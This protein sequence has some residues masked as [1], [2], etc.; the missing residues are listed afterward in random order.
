MPQGPQPSRAVEWVGS[1][2]EVRPEEE[3]RDR[4]RADA[5]QGAGGGEW[6]QEMTVATWAEG[7]PSSST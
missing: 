3:D 4:V 1:E 6:C 2:A 7:P 5:V